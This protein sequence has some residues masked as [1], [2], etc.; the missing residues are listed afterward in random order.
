[1]SSADLASWTPF[2]TAVA[3]AAAA[4]AGLLFVA[5]SINVREILRFPSLPNRAGETITMLIGA[6]VAACVV[7]LPGTS[8]RAVG[9]LLVVV[10]G[11][12]WTLIVVLQRRGFKAAPGRVRASP[13][14]GITPYV[15]TQT[16]TLP[17]FVGA[18]MVVAA[19]STAGLYLV[20]VAGL[21][22]FAVSVINAWV[23]LVE[24][25]R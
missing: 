25:L 2:F 24:I 7:L 16:A 21:L 10:T 4:L 14:Q 6:L 20:G 23:L 19:D 22:T 11:V 12:T 9:G 5:I 18:V 15:L 8:V 3:T 1:M 17:A 13:A